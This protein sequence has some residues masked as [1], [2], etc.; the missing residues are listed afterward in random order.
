MLLPPVNGRWRSDL[1]AE[2]TDVGGDCGRSCA[3]P[4]ADPRSG[5]CCMASLPRS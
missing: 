4:A 5:A 2:F 3:C 1:A